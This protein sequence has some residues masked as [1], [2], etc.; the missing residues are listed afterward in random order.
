ML[1]S[2]NISNAKSILTFFAKKT[3]HIIK[4]VPILGQIAETFEQ[5][6]EVYEQTSD[7]KEEAKLAMERCTEIATIITGC[8]DDKSNL[9][10]QQIQGIHLLYGQ[11]EEMLSLVKTYCLKNIA[12]KVISNDDFN[13]SYETINKR[14]DEYIQIVQLS[15]QSTMLQQNNQILD[16][17]TK[18]SNN[19]K[20]NANNKEKLSEWIASFGTIHSSTIEIKEEISNEGVSGV[21]YRGIKDG[22]MEVAVKDVNI[23]HRKLF[24]NLKDDIFRETFIGMVF[25]DPNIVRTLGCVYDQ[26]PTANSNGKLM[27]VM[28]YMKH[29]SLHQFIKTKHNTLTKAD[30]HALMYDAAKG[31]YGMHLKQQCHHDIKPGNMLIDDRF[32]VKICDLDSVKDLNA[33]KDTLKSTKSSIG[34]HTKNYA[35]PEYLKP[36]VTTYNFKCDIF[37]FAMSMYE[38]GT[39]KT[40]F[41]G[42]TQDQIS[43]ELM[44]KDSRPIIPDNMYDL[45]DDKYIKLMR[46]AWSTDPKQR[47]NMKEIVQ[48][49]QTICNRL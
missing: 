43:I 44:S 21:V 25:Q 27:I 35:A 26:K 23:Q 13:D 14:I 49:L 16:F 38:V 11:V 40:P 30:R 33:P 48:Q 12:M 5:V 4:N 28:E 32:N 6:Y 41:D 17:L 8:T 39:G 47:P 42:M 10:E 20:L 34:A 1:S 19:N 24:P 18:S 37:S 45:V 9:T 22:H 3:S 29:G 31:I 15:L 2:T 46:K 7:N 36:G